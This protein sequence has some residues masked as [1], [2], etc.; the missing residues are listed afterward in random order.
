VFGLIPDY[1]R[2]SSAQKASIPGR[3]KGRGRS[4]RT[5]HRLLGAIFRDLLKAQKELATEFTWVCLGDEIRKVRVHMPVTSSIGDGKQQDLNATR[6]A[7][8]MHAKHICRFCRTSY[9]NAN[10]PNVDCME[11]SISE[12]NPLF[13]NKGRCQQRQK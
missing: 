10:N 7:S 11:I 1:D 3:V 2:K 9:K 5:I 8:H 13:S 4:C 6:Y 12:I